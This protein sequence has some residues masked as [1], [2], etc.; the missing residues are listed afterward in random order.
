MPGFLLFIN[1]LPNFVQNA[2]LNIYAD[3]VVIYCSSTDIREAQ[4]NLQKVMSRVYEWYTINKLSLSI[5]KCCTMLIPGNNH[6][7]R[8][9]FNIS[10]GNK[11]LD[12]VHSMKYL[13]VT[14][15]DDLNGDHI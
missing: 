10:V 6:V 12:H 9:N 4:L 1:D 15:D 7:D 14:I 5:E 3:D 2:Q 11:I 13:G 8:S